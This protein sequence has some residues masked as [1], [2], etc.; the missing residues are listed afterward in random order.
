MGGIREKV[1]RVEEL[2]QAQDIYLINSVRG[3]MPVT[4]VELPQPVPD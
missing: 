4:W 3:W 1:I 2:V